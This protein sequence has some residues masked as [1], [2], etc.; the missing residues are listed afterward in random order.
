MRFHQAAAA[1]TTTLSWALTTMILSRFAAS[2]FQTPS[3]HGRRSLS[4]HMLTTTQQV[5][6]FGSSSYHT[7]TVPFRTFHSSLTIHRATIQNI[8]Q[9]SSSSSSSLKGMDWVQGCILQVLNQEFDSK[10]VAKN[11]ALAKLQPKKKKKK[12]KQQQQDEDTT[13]TPKE[14]ELTM[15]EKEAIGNAAAEAALPFGRRD[16][17]VTPATKLE[18]GDYQCNAAMSLARNVGL[19]PR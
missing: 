3:H 2:A 12:K 4:R 14:P 1:T 13:T 6:T 19:S 17:M 8:E 15:E 7:D 10:Q 5:T 16:C 11:A 9:V 18:F